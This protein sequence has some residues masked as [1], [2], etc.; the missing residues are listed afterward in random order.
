VLYALLAI[1]VVGVLFV[2]AS[3]VLPAGEQ[4]AAP[5][6]DDP[7]WTLPADRPLD[8]TDVADVRLPIALRGYRF[9][10]TDFL[11]DRLS[12][13]LRIRDAEIRRLGGD[14]LRR[15]VLPAATGG[16]EAEGDSLA[17][18]TID[19]APVETASGDVAGPAPIAASDA[20]TSAPDPLDSADPLGSPGPLGVP[21]PEVGH[22]PERGAEPE[23]GAEAETQHDRDGGHDGPG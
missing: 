13:E 9:A 5:V 17:P 7:A 21:E 22:D 6:R 14:P 3:F 16:F 19:F 15:A 18:A 10:E 1:L 12:D 20:A 2:I 11:L 8:A 4:I 23:L